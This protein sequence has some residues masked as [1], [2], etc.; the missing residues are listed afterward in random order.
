MHDSEAT[1]HYS[2]FFSDKL[3]GFAKR[4]RSHTAS[5][6][7]NKGLTLTEYLERK[8]KE[9][10]GYG[11]PKKKRVCLFGFENVFFLPVT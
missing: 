8:M 1:L 10:T 4:K 6:E 5:D 11:K 7:K 3:D 9:F 2:C